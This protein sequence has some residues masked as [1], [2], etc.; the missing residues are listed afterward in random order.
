MP[1]LINLDISDN[2]LSDLLKRNRSFIEEEDFHGSDKLTCYKLKDGVVYYFKGLYVVIDP[3]NK[4]VELVISSGN[5][6]SISV[7]TTKKI[8]KKRQRFITELGLYVTMLHDFIQSE[9]SKGIVDVVIYED[10]SIY[11]IRENLIINHSV[12]KKPNGKTKNV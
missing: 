8:N 2:E 10:H 12:E 4:V 9:R 11:D 5:K 3:N 6:N 1:T 7:V